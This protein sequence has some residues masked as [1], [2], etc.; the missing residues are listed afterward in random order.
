MNGQG[1]STNALFISDTPCNDF[2]CHLA[3]I[4]EFWRLPQAPVADCSAV[5][6][7][8]YWAPPFLNDKHERME[9]YCGNP[10]LSVR[11]VPAMTVCMPRNIIQATIAINVFVEDGL[12][13]AVGSAVQVFS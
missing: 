6:A 11:D 2:C 9:R 13:K 8:L 7:L 3:L 4:P 5:V 10:C 12:H 1:V